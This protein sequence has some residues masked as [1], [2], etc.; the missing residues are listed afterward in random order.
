M[1]PRIAK[2]HQSRKCN[3]SIAQLCDTTLASDYK[4]D[5]AE[6]SATAISVRQCR[7]IMHRPIDAHWPISGTQCI[8]QSGGWVV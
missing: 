4:L 5:A 1:G 6:S 7:L 2:H 3:Q 8:D